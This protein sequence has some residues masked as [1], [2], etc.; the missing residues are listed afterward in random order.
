MLAAKIKSSY[1][2]GFTEKDGL[3]TKP[4]LGKELYPDFLHPF[5]TVKT[6]KIWYGTTGKSDIRTLLGIKVEYINYIT[7]ERK[8]TNYQGAPIEGIDVKVKEL[9]IEEGDYLS[10]FNIGFDD[11]ITHIKFKT[12]K[13]NCIEYGIITDNEKQSVNEINEENN[14]ILNIK[15]Y[16]NK[17]GI[18]SIGFEY[19]NYRDFYFI[20][21]INILRLR[22]KFKDEN[23]RNKMEKEYPK[24]NDGMKCIYKTCSLSD[25]FFYKILR[26][27]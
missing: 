18:Q 23:S 24:L 16:Y 10:K 6:L 11:Y 17:N 15:G 5:T 4:I 3:D 13:R 20:R 22:H 21:W 25:E 8:E 19:I 27:L 12:K 1:L 2:Y 9:D 14:I 26:Y 7:C